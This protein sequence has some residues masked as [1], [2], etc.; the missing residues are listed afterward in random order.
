MTAGSDA[1][2]R[3]NCSTEVILDKDSRH[4]ARIDNWDASCRVACRNLKVA[5]AATTPW[6]GAGP[7]LQPKF[8]PCPLSRRPRYPKTLKVRGCSPKR[9]GFPPDVTDKLVSLQCAMLFPGAFSFFDSP[10]LHP[11]I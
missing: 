8:S 3:A 2:D 4:E 11:L 7:A 6:V 1:W 10:R 5:R 9:T